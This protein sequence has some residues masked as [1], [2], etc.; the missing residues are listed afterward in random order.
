MMKLP[1]KALLYRDWKYSKLFMPILFLELLYFIFVADIIFLYQDASNKMIVLIFM[2][3]TILGMSVTLFNYDRKLSNYTLV[4]S[5]P[6]TRNEI[7]KSKWL[8]GL[9]NIIIP[10][11]TVYVLANIILIL[12]YSWKTDIPFVTKILSGDMLT[13]FMMFG[14]VMLIQSMNGS[15]LFGVFTTALFAT[16][17]LSLVYLIYGVFLGYYGAAGNLIPDYLA[18]LA[19]SNILEIIFGGV[20]FLFG[21]EFGDVSYMFSPE[22]YTYMGSMPFFVLKVFLLFLITVLFFV[23]SSKV[24]SQNKFE[25]NGSISTVGKLERLYKIVMAYFIGFIIHQ[26]YF[27]IVIGP[28]LGLYKTGIRPDAVI[29]CCVLIP[30][31]LYFVMGKL[32]DVYNKR[33]S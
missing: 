27:N 8:V 18:P 28:S 4:A 12:R 26:V 10:F 21:I 17:P 14:F 29:L 19:S 22:Y 32:I 5:M 33:F 3:I 1:N 25:E 16:F 30:I 23:L 9:Y 20:W 2:F 7:M 11:L 24:Y 31:P 6:F 13:A 15:S